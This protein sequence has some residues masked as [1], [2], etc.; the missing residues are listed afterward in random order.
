MLKK[1]RIKFVCINMTIITIM[2]VFILCTIIHFTRQNME[3]ADLQMM[4]EIAADPLSLMHP[5][6]AS[7]V[8]LPYFSLKVTSGGELVEAN[9]I[10]YNLSDKS[11]LTQ[12]ADASFSAS[13]NTGLLEDYHLRFLH[14]ATPTDHFLI[15]LDISTEITTLENLTRNCILIGIAS[16]FV[17]LGIS[18]F[19]AN[20][21]VRPVEQAWKQQK[22]FI[23]D[24]SHELKTP[25]TVIRT[26]AELLP[27]PDFTPE[28]KHRF[29]DNILTMSRQMQG[30][31]EGMLELSRIDSSSQKADMQNIDF[32]ALVENALY[33]FEPLFFENGL[34]LDSEIDREVRVRG[35]ENHLKQVVEILLDNALKYAVSPSQVK[36][37]LQRHK[38]DCVFSVSS[39]GDTISEENLKNIFRRFYR[40]NE[41]RSWDGSYGL[42]LSIAQ[43]IVIEHHGKIWAESKDGINTFFVRL[44]I[45]TSGS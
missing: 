7:P 44:R 32:S 39:H 21:A 17:F 36:V 43:S 28:Q 5:S 29:S 10:Y 37:K 35:S 25:L 6:Y 38:L 3:R 14:V 2:L 11:F 33:P 34:E 23:A 45:L 15:F 27:S 12:L 41:S 18:I 1:L 26:N 40:M 30:L 8:R 4:Q 9:S 16:F 20:W 13:E 19:F 31:V 24:A 42:G 22:Q